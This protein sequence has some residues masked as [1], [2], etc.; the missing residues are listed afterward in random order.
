[1]NGPSTVT[2]LIICLDCIYRAQD[3]NEA[4]YFICFDFT[5]DFDK[6]PQDILLRKLQQIG[7]SGKLLKLLTKKLN[8]SECDNKQQ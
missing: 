4:L 2:Q 6:V 3:V 8:K 5:E 1:M 7:E